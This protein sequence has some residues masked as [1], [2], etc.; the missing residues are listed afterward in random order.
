[1]HRFRAVDRPLTESEMKE[2]DSWSS[3][4]SPSSTGITYIYHYG[5]FKKSPEKVVPK[6]FDAMLYVDSWGTR[7]LMFRFPK[8]LVSWSEISDYKNAFFETS[9]DFQKVG[10]YIIMD[11]RWNEEGGGGWMEEEDYLLDPLIPLRQEILNGD[12]RSLFLCW[13]KVHQER[14]SVYGEEDYADLADEYED[15]KLLT[16][17]IPPN[18]QRINTAHKSLIEI[19]EINENLIAAAAKSSKQVKDQS[20]DY[21]ALLQNLSAKEKD[22]FLLRLLEDSSRLGLEFRKKLETF[23][24]SPKRIESNRLSWEQLKT[25]LESLR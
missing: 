8:K 12:F 4:F 11:L 13:L 5:S 9:L 16:P 15:G 19:F 1:M 20:K 14:M 23:E 7:Q 2:I 21:T 22:A 6:Y 17:P 10:D 25:N 3:R 18:L 24:D